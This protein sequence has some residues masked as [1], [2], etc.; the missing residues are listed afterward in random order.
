MYAAFCGKIGWP[1]SITVLYD[2]WSSLLDVPMY[3]SLELELKI[4]CF[5]VT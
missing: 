5:Y 2:I 1:I 3:M 4:M